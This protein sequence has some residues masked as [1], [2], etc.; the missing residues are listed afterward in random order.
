E[1]PTGSIVLAGEVVNSVATLTTSHPLALG[2]TFGS[3]SGS[4][5]L[6]NNTFGASP[7]DITGVWFSSI[8]GGTVEPALSLPALGEE[9]IYE[10]WV[11]VGGARLSTG[12]FRQ[13]NRLDENRR[14]SDSDAPGFP[15]EDFLINA[16]EG[17]TFPLNPSG[18][19]VYVTVEPVPDDSPLPFGI[20]V[21]SGSIP[22][23][24]AARTPYALGGQVAVPG[25]TATL[26]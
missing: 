7:A 9:W 3:A 14:Y 25:G 23:S 24:P 17:V 1:E 16:P 8:A 18:G 21:L 5:M 19:T 10:G 20:T 22:A 26:F 11:E 6:Y 2:T 4:F 13:T 15:G 12:Y